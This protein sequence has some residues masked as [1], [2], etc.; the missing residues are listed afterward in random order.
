MAEFTAV[1]TYAPGQRTVM[2]VVEERVWTVV[3]A[4]ED[5]VPQ[6]GRVGAR[7][8]ERSAYFAFRAEAERWYIE[9]IAEGFT[10]QPLAHAATPYFGPTDSH[11]NCWAATVRKALP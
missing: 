4:E 8:V 5:G 9:Q 7:E 10:P 3:A 6:P 11:S 1:C 2:G